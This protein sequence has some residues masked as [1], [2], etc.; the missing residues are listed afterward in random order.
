MSVTPGAEE[1][2][3]TVNPDEGHTGLD[4]D[5]AQRPDVNQEAHDTAEEHGL[6]P[7]QER[8]QELEDAAKED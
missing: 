5:N 7:M 2:V 8:R 1:F 6:D 3:M 4:R